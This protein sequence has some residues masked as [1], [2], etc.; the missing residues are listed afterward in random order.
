MHVILGM[1][2]VGSPP[3][4]ERSLRAPSCIRI[5]TWIA[6]RE[7]CNSRR[8]L[9][10]FPCLASRHLTTS[11]RV[12]S[13]TERATGRCVLEEHRRRR[14][15]RVADSEGA[16]GAPSALANHRR[17]NGTLGNCRSR[18]AVC[19]GENAHDDTAVCDTAVCLLANAISLHVSCGRRQ[20]TGRSQRFLCAR[21]RRAAKLGWPGGD[22]TAI[23]A[24]AWHCPAPPCDT[25]SD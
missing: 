5:G 7:S 24:P 19:A 3:G 18:T 2:P 6:G 21:R 9:H 22:R 14:F 11:D 15:L 8:K 23:E 13:G 20:R 17:I 1:P 10:Q 12:L 4:T 25:A 16:A